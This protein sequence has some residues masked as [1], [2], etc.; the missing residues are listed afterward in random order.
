MQAVE[1]KE[2]ELSISIGGGVAPQSSLSAALH[3]NLTAELRNG[4][5]VKTLNDPDGDG[6][7]DHG[8]VEQS[9]AASSTAGPAPAGLNGQGLHVDTTA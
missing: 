7:N 3:A 8:R 5:Q 4:T 2:Q 6:D 9:V 1:R